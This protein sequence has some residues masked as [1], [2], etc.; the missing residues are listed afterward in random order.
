MHAFRT[1][2]ALLLLLLCLTLPS[3]CQGAPQEITP[4]PD[5]LPAEVPPEVIPVSPEEAASPLVPSED[6]EPPAPPEED[7]VSEEEPNPPAPPEEKDPEP[8]APPE[9]DPAPPE[10]DPVPQPARENQKLYVLMYHSI[11]PDE[12]PCNTWMRTASQFREDLQWLAGNGYST[13]LPSELAAGEPLP[14]RAVM[15][16]FDDGYENNYTIAYPIL[17]EFQCK[18]VISLIVSYQDRQ[19]PGWLT[20]DMCAEMLKSGL[21]EIGSHTYDCHQDSGCGIRRLEGE[22]R[23]DYESRVLT[24]I[25]DSIDLIEANLDTTVRFFAYPNGIT[26]KWASDYLKEHFAVTVT[27]RYGSSDLSKGLFD[28]NRCNISEKEPPSFTLPGK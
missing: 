3:A 18:A 19:E 14:E 5:E 23:E 25:Q 4:V 13:V 10:E 11:V 17:Q 21:V 6:S 15:L 9:E 12:V 2:A 16:T 22:C 7:A 26:E 20:W 28:L 24:D 27:T 1:G 8:P